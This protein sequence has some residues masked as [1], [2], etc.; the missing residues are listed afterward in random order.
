MACLLSFTRAHRLRSNEEF[1]RLWQ[2]GKRISLPGTRLLY[3]PNTHGAPRLGISIAKKQTRLAV[4]RNRFKRLV[5]EAF[6][7]HRS[8]LPAVDMVVVI[9]KEFAAFSSAEQRYQLVS[10][11]EKL[12]ARAKL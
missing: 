1:K 12:A 6:R 9:Y 8:Q 7:Q 5:R 2:S 3:L 4:Q 10:V 11:W